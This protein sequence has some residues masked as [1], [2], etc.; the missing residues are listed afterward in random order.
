MNYTKGEWEILEGDEDFIIIDESG[1][2]LCLVPFYKE[3]EANAHLIAAAVNA[4]QS[5]NQDN[6][7]AVAESIKDMY[8]A[9]KA[10]IFQFAVAV[11]D[12]RSKDKEVYEQANE[13]LAKAEGGGNENTPRS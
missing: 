13:A 2:T 10:L 7:M 6:P 5:V 8:E 4:C 12:V 3:G 11:D 9:L 1:N